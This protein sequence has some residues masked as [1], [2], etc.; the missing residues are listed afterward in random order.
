MRFNLV[1][2]AAVCL[3]ALCAQASIVIDGYT[4]ATNDRFTNSPSFIASGFDLSG[5][6]QSSSGRWATLISPNVVISANHLAPSTGDVINFYA[7]NNPN[8]EVVQR[9]ITSTS[10][11]V[12]STDLWLGVLN[13]N[14]PSSIRSYNYATQILSGPTSPGQILLGDA[15]I[16]QNA[17]AYLMG[18]SP[19][20]HPA[21]QSQ[22]IGRNLITGFSENV[23]FGGTD[24]DT[25]IMRYDAPG[26]SAYT[27]YEAHFSG[28]D[29][30]GP[31]FIQVGND[32]VLVGT[33]AFVLSNTPGGPV[34]ASAVNYVGNQASNISDFVA[35][36]A[37]PEPSSIC[38]AVLAVGAV[39]G[40]GFMARRRSL[41]PRVTLRSDV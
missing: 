6:G 39:V 9:T 10:I 37:V 27:Q 13:A 20:N 21:F 2:F 35:I 23:D 31:M 11:R 14:V 22:A 19:T 1:G 36:N 17:N 7:S 4:A 8:S 33:N 30:G 25:L 38:L 29:S 15:G 5:V 12:G 16:F 24:N 34:L 40:R 18:L 26:N 28:G 41:L 3:M 32:L